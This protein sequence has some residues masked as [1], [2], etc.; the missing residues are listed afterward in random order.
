MTYT[1]G[2]HEL[3]TMIV[4]PLSKGGICH[5]HMACMNHRPRVYPCSCMCL[6]F[7]KISECV[8]FYLEFEEK[9]PFY[10]ILKFCKIVHKDIFLA[11]GSH[12]ASVMNTGQHIHVCI[13]IL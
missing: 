5:I 7:F 1:Y 9:I 4:I 2:M 13:H 11:D 8:I 10:L 12:N 6:F 3:N